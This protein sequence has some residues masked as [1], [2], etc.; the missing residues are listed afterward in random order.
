MVKGMRALTLPPQRVS[1]DTRVGVCC[2]LGARMGGVE[3]TWSDIVVRKARRA[4]LRNVVI[5]G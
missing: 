2:G 3:C 5:R 4:M 1:G